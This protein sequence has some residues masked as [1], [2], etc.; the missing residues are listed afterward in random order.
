MNKIERLNLQSKRRL[1]MYDMI[2]MFMVRYYLGHELACLIGVHA[3]PFVER[4]ARMSHDLKTM[5]E[6][7]SQLMWLEDLAN[8]FEDLPV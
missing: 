5:V 2:L 3:R 8:K 7:H 1:M 6:L 4:T